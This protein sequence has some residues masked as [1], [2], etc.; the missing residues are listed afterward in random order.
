VF[1]PGNDGL[2]TNTFFCSDE[3]SEAWR[4]FTPLLH[5]IETERIKPIPYKFGTRGPVRY[6][7]LNFNQQPT[8]AEFFFFLSSTR[9]RPTNLSA[10]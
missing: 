7:T 9:P 10:S 4:I 8:H 1:S 5:Q 2:K 6:R 3:L